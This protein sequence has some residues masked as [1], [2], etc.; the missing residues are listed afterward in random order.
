MY[1][2]FKSFLCA[3]AFEFVPSHGKPST[4]IYIDIYSNVVRLASA[5][6][7]SSCSRLVSVGESKLASYPIFGSFIP[8]S[9]CNSQ[10]TPVPS[11]KWSGVPVN[12]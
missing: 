3:C 12:A 9:N 1:L 6:S 2:D 5:F 11:R 7:S 10:M 8:A 4:V